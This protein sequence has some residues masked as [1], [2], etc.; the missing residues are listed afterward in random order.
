MKLDGLG[1]LRQ[2]KGYSM[3]MMAD[4]LHISLEAYVELEFQLRDASHSERE[5]LR[6]LL[7]IE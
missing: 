6:Q 2:L 5:I 1:R 4:F 7:K 3:H